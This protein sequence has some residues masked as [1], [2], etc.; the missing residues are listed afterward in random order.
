[1]KKVGYRSFYK[2]PQ[3]RVQ[4]E[5]LLSYN[6]NGIK[7]MPYMQLIAAM[8][9]MVYKKLNNLSDIMSA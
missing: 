8:L 1:M 6:E 9:F 2:V 7:I 5:I 4:Y 3:A